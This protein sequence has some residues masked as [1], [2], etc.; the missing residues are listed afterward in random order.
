MFGSQ[1]Y[2][3]TNVKDILSPYY[4]SIISYVTCNMADGISIKEYPICQ[5]HNQAQNDV[6][7]HFLFHN[8]VCIPDTLYLILVLDLFVSSCLS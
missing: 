5:T 4:N 2:S 7:R 1:Q 3:V 8:I 6:F